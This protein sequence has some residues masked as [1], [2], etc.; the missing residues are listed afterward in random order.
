MGLI[1]ASD[2]RMLVDRLG[3]DAGLHHPERYVLQLT[4][5]GTRPIDALDLGM[6]RWEDAVTAMAL[7]KWDLVRTEVFTPS[8]EP[9]V[10]P[11]LP[12]GQVCP[13]PVESQHVERSAVIR[14]LPC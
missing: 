7:P 11:T 5:P 14:T 1:E 13:L 9:K 2:V 8:A 3:A 4:L 12:K 10:L 6:S